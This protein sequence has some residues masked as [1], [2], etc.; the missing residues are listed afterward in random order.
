MD[1]KDDQLDA[2]A[3]ALAEAGGKL[4]VARPDNLAELT[5]LLR[6]LGRDVIKVSEAGAKLTEAKPVNLADVTSLLR[7][8]GQDFIEAAE[9]FGYAGG[10]TKP[11]MEAR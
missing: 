7:E 1:T 2:F 10:G 6:E 9:A 4:A 3:K 5:S 11:T 8:V